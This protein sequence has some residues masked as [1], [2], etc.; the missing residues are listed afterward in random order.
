MNKVKISKLVEDRVL[1]K[2]LDGNHGSL[3]PTAS[4]YVTEGIPFLLASNLKN[5][6]VDFENCKHLTKDRAS[7]LQKGFARDGDV[8]LTHKGT[9]GEVAKLRSKS[10]PFIMLTPQVTY[11]RVIDSSKLDAD[12]LLHF[13]RSSYFQ[14]Q[15]QKFSGGGTRAYIGITKQLQLEINLPDIEEQK[16]IAEILSTW[17]EAIESILKKIKLEEKKLTE[18][19]KRVIRGHF[20]TDEVNFVEFGDVFNRIT[21]KNTIRCKNVLTV[22]AQMGLV[23]QLE[24]YDKTVAGK[25]LDNY[26]L[27]KKGE[28]AYNRSYSEGYPLGAIKRLDDY[29]KGV[30]STLY[31]CFEIDHP[32]ANSDFY[33]HFFEGGGLNH[34]LYKIAKE[35][36]RNHGLLNVSIKDFLKTKVQ[37]PSKKDQEKI[38]SLLNCQEK[39]ISF[40]KKKKELLQKQKKGLMQRLLTGKVRCL[41]NKR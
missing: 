15:L 40:L 14:Y 39:L 6:K 1:E 41:K 25:N 7:E 22:S 5:G 26:Y 3:H 2:P 33:R 30:I 19:Y 18:F 12:Y 32:Q 23:S 13:F 8:L 17:D 27:I 11:Y 20:F 9:V 16:K 24:Y 31:I 29:E 28:F 10:Y 37:F 34:E 4:E 36:S 38:A 35:G 21:R